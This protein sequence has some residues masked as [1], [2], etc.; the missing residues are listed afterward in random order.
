MA[1]GWYIVPYVTETAGR[2]PALRRCPVDDF[3]A[4]IEADAGGWREVEVLGGYAIV[5]VRASLT[6]LAA[7]NAA[8]GVMRLPKD[9]LTSPLSD[10]TTLQ[11]S[12]LRQKLLDMGYTAQ[13]LTTRFGSDLGSHTLGDVLRFAASR[14][15]EP[16]WDA[17]AGAFVYDG[18][19][20][21]PESIDTL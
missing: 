14:R 4:Q 8:N 9:D 2:F 15:R 6:T 20:R 13:E 18:N 17:Q 19:I 5:C 12:R 7:I 1:V 11:K 3:T 16:R 10:L 21:T